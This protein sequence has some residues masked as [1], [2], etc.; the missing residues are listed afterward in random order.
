VSPKLQYRQ[1]SSASQ[2]ER[3]HAPRGWRDEVTRTTTPMLKCKAWNRR[4]RKSPSPGDTRFRARSRSRAG[5]VIP[6]PGLIRIPLAAA[7]KASRPARCAAGDRLDRERWVHAVPRQ[8]AGVIGSLACAASGAQRMNPGAWR[9]RR[10]SFSQQEQ[11]AAGGVSRR[12][13]SY[14][15]ES[16][17]PLLS[18][19]VV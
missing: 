7:G 13:W 4:S 18:A 9:M 19:S 16:R 6:C 1:T 8:W 12:C 17:G 5:H 10:L 11:V 14:D 15:R 3:H 2:R